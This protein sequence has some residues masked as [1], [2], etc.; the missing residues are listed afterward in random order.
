MTRSLI[1]CVLLLALAARA[2]AA[3]GEPVVGQI[4]AVDLTWVA[5][6]WD[7]TAADQWHREEAAAL[8]GFTLFGSLSPGGAVIARLE[9]PW[10]P[11]GGSGRPLF[12]IPGVP[13]GR[14]F[15]VAV[16]GLV[17]APTLVPPSAWSEVVV[18]S[19]HCAAPPGPPF[20]RGQSPI[21][22]GTT[23]V[24]L[25]WSDGPGCTA[26]HYEVVAGYS[27]GAA[28]ASRFS[29]AGRLAWGVAPPGTY[30]VRVH[31]INR[32]GRSAPSNEV[33]I[34][35]AHPSC[36]GPGAP[37]LS[38]AVEG[39]QVTLTWSAP[40]PGSRPLTLYRVSAGTLPG[41]SNAATVYV[42]ADVQSFVANAPPG[43]YYVRVAA[44]NG[45]GGTF[46]FGAPSNEVVVDVP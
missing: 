41:L 22:G 42:A 13:Y 4:A 15:V 33:R 30:F 17:A 11:G 34:D 27:P 2:N 38:A 44:G 40:T 26:E 19:G 25:G 9:L 10:P 36:S 12:A 28:D 32:Y 23:E 46:S 20:L 1:L 7:G 18:G 39:S 6:R 21:P 35:V 43:R 16:R 37:S 8:G 5:V 45:C 31:A 14:Y 3:P 29:V 24:Q